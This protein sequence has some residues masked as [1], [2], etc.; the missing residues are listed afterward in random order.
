MHESTPELGEV[1]EL[2]RRVTVPSGARERVLL[3]LRAGT[4]ERRK[5]IVRLGVAGAGMLVGAAAAALGLGL[6]ARPGEPTPT[7]RPAPAAAET[8]SGRALPELVP[9]TPPVVSADDR[10]PERSHAPVTCP[11]VSSRSSEGAEPSELSQQVRAYQA[12][13]ELIPTNP[14][15]ALAALRA[16]RS[17]WPGS[18]L[19]QEADL[20]IVQTLLALGQAE[21]ARQAARTFVARYPESPRAADMRV[22]AGMAPQQ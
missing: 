22:V 11:A 15:Q 20:R 10:E 8:H 16:F 9:P 21:D 3:G 14:A 19:G 12:A 1:R 5:W 17:R 7:T 6:V 18:A 2:L 4:H 13:V